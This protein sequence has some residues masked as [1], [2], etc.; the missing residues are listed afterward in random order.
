MLRDAA[1]QAQDIAPSIQRADD[2]MGD[3]WNKSQTCAKRQLL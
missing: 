3:W 1:A 2:C